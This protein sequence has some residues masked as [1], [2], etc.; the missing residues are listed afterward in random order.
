MTRGKTGISASVAAFWKQLLNLLYPHTCPFC[1][2]IT[3]E[4]VCREC[5]R[6]L[7][8]LR[9]PRCMRCGKPVQKEKDEYCHD[10]A[11]T[12]H[13]YDRG[14]SLWLHQGPVKESVYQ[15]KY[16][17][18]RELGKFY[19]SELI[20]RYRDIIE[21]WNPDAFIPIPLHT[22]RRRRRGYNQAEILAAELGNQLGIPVDTKSLKRKYNTAPQKSMSHSERKKNLRHAFSLDGKYAPARTVILVDD[23]YT[24]GNTIDAAACLLKKTGVQ[25]VYFLTISIGQGY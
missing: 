2:K 6:K 18:R 10:C 12:N 17:N 24:T 22:K 9:D 25:K 20:L 7:P 15:F 23:I 13:Y 4:T 14:L 21:K 1:R 5:T 19:A 16:H 3:K 11:H 8:V